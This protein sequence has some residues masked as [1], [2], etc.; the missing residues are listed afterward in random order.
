MKIL[1]KN[2]LKTIVGAGLVI[3][4]LSARG[5]A[6]S[7]MDVFSDRVIGG[8][9]TYTI[10]PIGKYNFGTTVN[11][12]FLEQVHGSK[13]RFRGMAMI[14]LRGA[15]SNTNINNKNIQS[16]DV[17]FGFKFGMGWDK[18]LLTVS[19]GYSLDITS[20]K[21]RYFTDSHSLGLIWQIG[22]YTR[23]CGD[24]ILSKNQIVYDK[25]HSEPYKHSVEIG[26]IYTLYRNEKS[27]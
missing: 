7:N 9:V 18:V 14:G 5:Q 3:A 23:L 20:D 16:Y 1:K 11:Y 17:G 13:S 10:N 26:I 25:K 24:Y 2:L 19:K 22:N 12:G 21:S 27:K 6:N 4:P 8:G 15:V